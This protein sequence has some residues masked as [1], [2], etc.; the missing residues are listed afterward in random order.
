MSGKGFQ[1]GAGSTGWTSLASVL[2]LGAKSGTLP[3]CLPGQ[4][5]GC[6]TTKSEQAGDLQYVG[7][8][9]SGDWLWFGLSTYADWAKVGTG[10]VP[11]VDFDTTGDGKPDYE[12]VVQ[13][14]PS[15]D[16]LIAATFDLNDPS[17][18]DDQP[19]N[20]NWGDVDTNVFDTNALTIPVSKEF[21]GV[22]STSKPVT[23]TVGTFNATNGTVTDRVGPVVVRRRHP[24]VQHGRAAL[25]RPGRHPDRLHRLGRAPGQGAAPAPARG[26]RQARR[27]AQPAASG[28]DDAEPGDEPGTGDAVVRQDLPRTPVT[29]ARGRSCSRA[30]C[31]PCRSKLAGSSQASKAARSRGHSSSVM[32]NQAVSRLRPLVTT[33]CRK[34]PS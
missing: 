34:V 26:E 32:A 15:S 7:A 31:R 11:F 5:G 17:R 8:G 23:Y 16:V 33:A 24:G 25:P 9:S 18:E 27:G 12:T 29:Q 22:G 21:I 6:A 13:T 19:V 28:G 14:V 1:Q 10:L 2:Q 3:T 30:R 20:F 4:A